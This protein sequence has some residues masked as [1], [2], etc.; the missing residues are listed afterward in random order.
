MR[1]P[2]LFVQ[3]VVARA[4]D[5]IF[6]KIDDLKVHYEFKVRVAFVELYMENLCDLL[7]TK[8]ENVVD[9]RE[10]PEQGVYIANLTELPISSSA[11][12]FEA[13][14]RG[15]SKRATAATNMNSVSSRSHAIFTIF[16][17][18]TRRDESI[19]EAGPDKSIEGM[20]DSIKVKFHLVDLAGS[21]RAKKTGA[22][23]ERYKEGV[24][25]NMG[26]LSLGNVIAA[27]GED[28]GPKGHISYRDSKLT[29]LL[30]DSLGGN[31]HTLMIA[32]V[33]PADSNI[34]ESLNTLRYAD[35]ARKIKNK[36][37]VN[38]GT[39]KEE[40][41]RLRR[42]NTELKMQ[43]A[44]GGGGGGA[45]SG[46]EAK[47]LLDLRERYD[48][49]VKE[50]KDLTGAL[51]VLRTNLAS[52]LSIN[53][54]AGG[55]A[56]NEE[57]LDEEA[58][59]KKQANLASQ[60]ANLNDVLA[61][62]EQLASTMMAN[63]EKIQ[64][65][66]EKY[67]ISLASLQEELATLQQEREKL[68]SQSKSSKGN[69]NPNCKISEQ[70]RKRIQEPENQMSDL[71]KKVTEQSR[72]LK[73][74]EKTEKMAKKLA[75]EINQMK[76]NKVKL[77]KQMKEDAEKNRVW[78]QAK[79]KEVQ[80]L[81]QV[82][83]KQQVQIAKMET[84]H[85]KQQNVMKRKM[86]EASLANK[87]LQEVIDKQKNAKKMKAGMASGKPGLLGAAERVRS[88]VNHELDI[89]TTIKDAIQS[90]EVLMKDRAEL[91][92]QLTELRG[93]ARL[94]MMASDRVKID[95]KRKELQ[96]ELDATNAEISSLHK[97]IMEA[98]QSQD[99]DT[100]SAGGKVKSWIDSFQSMSEAKLALQHLFERSTDLISTNSQLK[101]E[102]TEAKQLFSDASASVRSLEDEIRRLKEEHQSEVL[103]LKTD[104]EE[105][106]SLLL[107]KLANPD[108]EVKDGDLSKYS[109][110]QAKLKKSMKKTKAKKETIQEENEEEFEEEEEEDSGE[111]DYDYEEDPDWRQTPLFRR[112]KTVKHNMTRNNS[113]LSTRR[114]MVLP[115]N[116][117]STEE[118][119]DAS[120]VASA[121]AAA[122]KRKSGSDIC[123]CKKSNCNTN[124]CACKKANRACGDACKCSSGCSNSSSEGGGGGVEDCT[125]GTVSLLSATFDISDV[126]ENLQPGDATFTAGDEH[127]PRQ[128]LFK[129]PA[130]SPSANLAVPK[131]PMKPLATPLSKYCD[132]TPAASSKRKTIFQSPLSESNDSPQ[133]PRPLFRTPMNAAN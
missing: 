53:D 2:Q 49:V 78:K 69:D 61:Q 47:E 92:K 60:L 14:V 131:S 40:V 85:V 33:S 9:L 125:A 100:D 57:D 41:A 65:M 4:V 88:M 94:T 45:L 84:M 29:R 118:D 20:P 58:M 75:D 103:Q 36:P 76:S 102:K 80:K 101:S 32:C 23:G 97:Q 86:Q 6:A 111:D 98:K 95:K 87:R 126:K 66:R 39:D 18:G 27:L 13:L 3:Q 123:A 129:S 35:R 21:E 119:N 64:E 28:N 127:Q 51:S 108:F 34:E 48:F 8:G 62:K 73:V 30:Q 25:I 114:T 77:I 31:S 122:N 50:N 59:E 133:L 79:E 72:A 113:T 99:S 56:D 1:L 112:L 120:V 124:R 67:E 24:S 74:N 130:N 5:K 71:R 106:K 115:G 37:I 52:D 42:E 15:S 44:T 91:S 19:S 110:F 81:K 109:E 38:R 46:I 54:N 82:E 68:E 116:N 11:D 70:R 55:D 107:S 117:D 128:Q 26:L 63:E 104:Y 10:H 22:T 93:Q 7:S 132:V 12:M 83:R 90:R 96:A 89:A 17:E 16:I 43:L 121:A 105:Q